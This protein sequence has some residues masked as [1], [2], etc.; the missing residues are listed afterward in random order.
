MKRIEIWF[1]FL[2]VIWYQ[3]RVFCVVLI[4]C[5]ADSQFL[6]CY[7]LSIFFWLWSYYLLSE[8]VVFIF[9]VSSWFCFCFSYVSFVNFQ[10]QWTWQII[11]TII[12]FCSTKFTKLCQLLCLG[13][14]IGEISIPPRHLH[15]SLLSCLPAKLMFS[16]FHTAHDLLILF[17][18]FLSFGNLERQI[19]EKY[20]PNNATRNRLAL[21]FVLFWNITIRITENI[22]YIKIS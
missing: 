22:I 3:F 2:H 6:Y 7:C 9:S 5:L 4:V 14:I 19:A 16:I 8:H 11:F 18:S 15:L 17:A 12:S 20:A 1:D 10:S 21:G 13:G